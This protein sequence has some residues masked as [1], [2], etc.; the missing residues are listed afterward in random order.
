MALLRI[1]KTTMPKGCQVFKWKEFNMGSLF[2]K[3]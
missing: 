3:I 2:M 1:I